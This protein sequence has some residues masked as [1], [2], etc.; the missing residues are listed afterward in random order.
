MVG[1]DSHARAIESKL[2]VDPGESWPTIGIIKGDALPFDRYL[3]LACLAVGER[4]IGEVASQLDPRIGTGAG[5]QQRT[6]PIANRRRP[7]KRNVPQG[8]P[9][10]EAAGRRPRRYLARASD[11]G[12]GS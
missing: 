1:V 9:A 5:N 11:P 10:V 6:Q 7:C 2:G 4:K 8:L 3:K 12:S